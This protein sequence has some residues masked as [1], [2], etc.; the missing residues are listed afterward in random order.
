MD[1]GV[2]YALPQNLIPNNDLA[3]ALNFFYDPLTGQPMTRDGVSR[4]STTG[5]GTNPNG[6]FFSSILNKWLVAESGTLY[7][8]DASTKAYVSIGALNGSAKPHFLDFNSKVLI[9]SGGV[10]ESTNGL[11]LA[12]VANAPTSYKIMA[13]GGRVVS[14]GDPSNPHRMSLSVTGDETE[15]ST[16]APA[17]GKE[18]EIDLNVGDGITDFNIYAGDIFVFKGPE[19]RGIYQLVIPSGDYSTA[20][21]KPISNINSS[22]NWHTSINA[23]NNL[24]FVD[25]NGWKSLKGVQNYGDIEQ[26][27]IGAK[28]NGVITPSIDKAQAFLFSNPFY[29]QIWLKYA[30]VQTLYAFHYLMNKGKGAFLP[31]E[32]KDLN[33]CSACYAEDARYLLIGMD[34]GYIY[35]L[36]RTLYTDN[37]VDSP[38]FFLTKRATLQ[39]ANI[40]KKLFQTAFAYQ[41]I[42]DGTVTLEALTDG[43]T[44]TATLVNTSITTGSDLLYEAT[45]YLNDATELLYGETLQSNMSRKMIWHYDL[46]YKV[47]VTS[48][49]LKL[50]R[51]EALVNIWGRRQT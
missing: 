5:V 50:D 34:D 51:L 40:T 19:Q 25:N 4:Y 8:L 24:Y 26:D 30:D 2:N 21:V 42:S 28:I 3:G 11:T 33:V 18:F 35:K 45:G 43:G 49:A 14:S 41:G 13:F 48:G 10:I 27:P 7:Y 31:Q 23:N 38:G 47:S 1:G 44:K 29:S 46:Q 20:Y 22:I 17:D 9:A 39:S 15:W 36:D 37:G 16:V 32:F 12:D 6:L